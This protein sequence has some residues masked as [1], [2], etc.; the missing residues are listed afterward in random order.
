[1]IEQNRGLATFFSP[2]RWQDSTDLFPLSG[3]SMVDQVNALSPRFVV[4]VGC[5]YNLFKQKIPNLV[6]IDLINP[7]A[8]LVCD[9][10]DA[11]I[12][13][14]SIDVVLALGSINFGDAENIRA[15]LSCIA[16]W[17]VPERG[18]V[19][20]RANPGEPVGDDIVVFPWSEDNIHDLGRAA[21][22]AVA[23]DIHRE[24]FTLRSGTPACRLHWVYQS[25]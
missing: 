3:W 17:L 24:H 13:Q 25:L 1:M 22:L 6:G 5:G 19:F 14:G 12:R 2:D 15:D 4:D 20:M 9:L 11:P 7:A 18:R 10:H 23:S 21:N 8:D 16:K